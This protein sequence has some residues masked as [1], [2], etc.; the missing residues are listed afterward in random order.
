MTAAVAGIKTD[1]SPGLAAIAI[2]RNV[3]SEN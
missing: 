1:Q 2:A 3:W